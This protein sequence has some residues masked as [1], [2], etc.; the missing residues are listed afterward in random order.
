MYNIQRCFS[1]TVHRFSKDVPCFSLYVPIITFTI[2]FFSIGS[3]Y[4]YYTHIFIRFFPY[5]SH[6]SRYFLMA[7]WPNGGG[8]LRAGG[9]DVVGRARHRSLRYHGGQGYLRDLRGF[10]EEIRARRLV[11]G[12]VGVFNLFNWPRSLK[13]SPK[14]WRIPGFPPK[15]WRIRGGNENFCV[16]SLKGKIMFGCVSMAIFIEKMMRNYGIEDRMG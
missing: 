8:P 3:L 14:K 15:K 2:V 7:R 1:H 9:L 5:V 12:G 13:Y 16:G 6:I 4:P 10:G 11:V